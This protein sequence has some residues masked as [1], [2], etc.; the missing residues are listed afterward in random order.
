MVNILEH[1]P[2]TIRV[3]EEVWR[4]SQR[5]GHVHIEVPYYNSPGAS[6]DPTH[7]RFFTEHSFDYFTPDNTTYLSAYN[8]YTKARFLI[9]AVEPVQRRW[10]QWS[11]MS[12]QWFL[13]HHLSTVHG[14]RVELLVLK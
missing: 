5:D 3:L 10:L 14:L 7:L 6:Q 9:L 2:D 1:L 12:V 11:P 8:Y 13:A 4:M